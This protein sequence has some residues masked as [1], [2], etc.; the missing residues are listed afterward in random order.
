MVALLGVS[1]WLAG[2]G[3]ESSEVSLTGAEE[4]PPI[5]TA[6]TG[7]ATAELDGDTLEVTGSFSGL[8]SD[9]APV[10]GSAAHVHNAPKGQSGPIVFNLEVMAN[11]DNRS[12][13]FRGSKALTDDEKALFRNGNLYVNIHTSANPT[14]ELRGQFQP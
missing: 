5:T 9:L 4:V 11:P 1:L 7:N 14:G 8:G 6:A 2:C 10:A 12:G 3:N 13:T